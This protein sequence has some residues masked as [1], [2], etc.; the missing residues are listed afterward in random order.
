MQTKYLIE[1]NESILKTKK[2]NIPPSDSRD[3]SMLGTI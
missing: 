3:M 1:L 2:E